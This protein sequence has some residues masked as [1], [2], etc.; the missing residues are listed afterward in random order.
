MAVGLP[1][2]HAL[3][4]HT[5]VCNLQLSADLTPGI[6]KS[7]SKIAK[8][9]TEA[10]FAPEKASMSPAVAAEVCLEVLSSLHDR[11]KRRV[12]AA[13]APVIAAFEARIKD[14]AARRASKKRKREA[15]EPFAPTRR[16]LDT[17][18]NPIRE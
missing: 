11:K 4:P 14:K 18:G 12:Q 9:A 3:S 7:A 17:L 15:G 10:K 2:P 6:A 8:M 16:V 5:F 13:A 1:G